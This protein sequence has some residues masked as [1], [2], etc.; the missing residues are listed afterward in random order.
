LPVSATSERYMVNRVTP[1]AAGSGRALDG[2]VLAVGERPRTRRYEL[3]VDAR[4]GLKLAAAFDDL[5][6]VV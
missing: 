3:G 6:L 2:T 4:H 1:N 5:A